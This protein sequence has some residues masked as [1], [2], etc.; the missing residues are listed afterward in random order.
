[1][2]ALI[3]KISGHKFGD[4]LEVKWDNKYGK[5][6][7]HYK[8]CA[9]CKGEWIFFSH[10]ESVIIWMRKL[11]PTRIEIKFTDGAPNE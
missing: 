5:G 3:C 4:M 9:R 6:E 10:S 7:R 11:Q 1:M 2:K 8:I